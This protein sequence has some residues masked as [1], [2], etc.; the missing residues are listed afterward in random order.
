MCSGVVAAN[1]LE[2]L[3]DNADVVAVGPG[4]GTGGWSRS[5]FAAVIESG[6]P[7]VV[8]ADAL[9]LLASSP[10]ACEQAILT[11]HPGEAARLLGKSA[12]DVQAN[13]LGALSELA[14]KYAGIVVL[15][16]A[17]SLVSSGTGVP[18]LC[19]AG[20]PGMAAP[21]MGDALTGIIVALLAQGLPAEMAAIAGVQIHAEAGDA[22]AEQG[23]RGMVA[24]DLLAE[25]RARVNL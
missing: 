1:D 10:V 5:L 19:C 6:L 17:G 22:A 3:L 16:G 24:S 9:N 13:R 11:P 20:N 8:D 23:E 12:S 4:L 14:Q 2:P 18:W 7:L 15:K 25:V 21:G